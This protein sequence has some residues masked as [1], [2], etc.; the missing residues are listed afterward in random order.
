MIDALSKAFFGTLAGSAALKGLSSRY[1]MR[2]QRSFAR[3][4][5]AGEGYDAASERQQVPDPQRE[6]GQAQ[7]GQGQLEPPPAPWHGAAS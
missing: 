4:F 7:E 2:S 1:G 6:P 3:R 5:V